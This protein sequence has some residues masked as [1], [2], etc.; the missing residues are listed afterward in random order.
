MQFWAIFGSIY[1][2]RQ[3]GRR[4]IILS[5]SLGLAVCDIIIGICFSYSDEYQEMF[6]IIFVV[7]IFYMVIYGLTIGPVVWM[8]IPEIIP[9]SVVPFAAT[10]NCISST[11]CLIISPVL[12]ANQGTPFVYFCFGGIT[13]LIT[14]INA[15]GMV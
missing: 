10:I 1:T 9:A 15:F 2:T 6:W 12:N 13:L 5:G 4:A 11:F 8:Y 3:F 14:L 7:L